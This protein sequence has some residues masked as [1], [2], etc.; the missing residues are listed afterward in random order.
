MLPRLIF[1]MP[2]IYLSPPDVQEGDLH[3]VER[4][5]RSNWVAPAGPD[6]GRFERALAERVGR[7]HAVAVSSGTAAL[8]LALMV[9]G[10]GPGDEVICPTLTFVASANPIRYLGAE[11]VLIDKLLMLLDGSG[12]HSTAADLLARL[13]PDIDEPRWRRLI[14]RRLLETWAR[15]EG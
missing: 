2:R 15:G 3:A 13:A 4:V 8:H 11:P 7:A 6:L 1:A 9:L 5:M 12:L 10:V 14:A